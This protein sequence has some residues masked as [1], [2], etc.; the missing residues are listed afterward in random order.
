MPRA[1]MIEH[2]I[3]VAR[4]VGAEGVNDP[5]QRRQGLVERHPQ[6]GVDHGFDS[7]EARL[8]RKVRGGKQGVVDIEEDSRQRRH[9]Y[10]Q[11][12]PRV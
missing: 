5:V 3:V 6:T 1:T 9:G 7:A 10:L 2:Q 8:L 12:V 11:Q 4:M